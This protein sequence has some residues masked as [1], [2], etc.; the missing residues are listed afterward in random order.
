[1]IEN[2]YIDD[3]EDCG[4]D[5]HIY[6]HRRQKVKGKAEEGENRKPGKQRGTNQQSYRH[7]TAAKLVSCNAVLPK[8]L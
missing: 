6:T 3:E 4:Y 8:S 2:T 1:V 5:N 7:W